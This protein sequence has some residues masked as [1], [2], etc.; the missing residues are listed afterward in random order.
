MVLRKV[1]IKKKWGESFAPFSLLLFSLANL[2][3]CLLDGGP[4]LQGICKFDQ[5]KEF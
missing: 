5:L 4:V 2:L 3:T 1:K